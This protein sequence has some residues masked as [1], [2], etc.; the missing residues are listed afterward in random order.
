MSACLNYYKRGITAW[1]GEFAS[2]FTLFAAL[3]FGAGSVFGASEP[4]QDLTE[5]APG[6]AYTNYHVASVPWSIHVARISRAQGDLEWHAIHAGNAA[7]GLNTV[8]EMVG[9]APPEW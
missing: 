7:L 4:G 5:F 9:S 8:A 6:V 1:S 2:I 3:A